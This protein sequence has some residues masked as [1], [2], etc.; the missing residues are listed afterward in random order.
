M[1]LNRRHFLALTGAAGLST[2]MSPSL[3]SLAPAGAQD[4]AFLFITD[5]NRS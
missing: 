1:L 3:H 5:C 4:F 2:V